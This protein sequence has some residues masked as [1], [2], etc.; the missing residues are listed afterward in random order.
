MSQAFPDELRIKHHSTVN[1]SAIFELLTDF[2]AS[3]SLGIITMPAG[4]LTDGAS[5][6]RIFWPIFQPFG[7]YFPAAILHDFLYSKSSTAKFPYSRKQADDLFKEAMFNV[8]VGWLSRGIIHGSV[9]SFG[10]KSWKKR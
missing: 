3:T 6:P 7:E 10:W 9:R 2:R 8:G 4:F 1:G 5:V